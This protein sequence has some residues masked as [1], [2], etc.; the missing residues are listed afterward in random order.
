MSKRQAISNIKG[1]IKI[2]KLEI[3]SAGCRC[4]YCR[5]TRKI[6]ARLKIAEKN[7]KE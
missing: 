2:A 5:A 6:V 3:L 7:L 1:A 4:T